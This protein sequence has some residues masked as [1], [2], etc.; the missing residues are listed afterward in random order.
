M[1][2]TPPLDWLAGEGASGRGFLPH[3][4]SEVFED[5]GSLIVER[6]PRLFPSIPSPAELERG[7]LTAGCKHVPPPWRG[8][9]GGQALRLAYSLGQVFTLPHPCSALARLTPP[10]PF[11]ERGQGRAQRGRG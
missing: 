5:F 6:P 2:L 3:Q 10:S 11:T 8:F 9:W 7:T 4:T 1:L